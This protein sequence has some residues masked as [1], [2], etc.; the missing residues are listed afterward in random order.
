MTPSPP[1]P[2]PAAGPLQILLIGSFGNSG[3]PVYR[4]HQQAAANLLVLV[5][6]MDVELPRLVRQRRL[7][8]RPTVLEV[9]DWVP[10]VQRCNPVNANWSD[11]RAWGL[12][13]QLI[14]HCDAVQVS[15]PG[16][17]RRLRPLARSVWL[18]RSSTTWVGWRGCTSAWPP[19]CPAITTPVD[20]M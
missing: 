13:S 19:C 8:G 12:L 6:G 20:R 14:P 4:V 15:S 2:S 10:G 18:A 16:L 5:M 1:A 11:S 17:L 3:D 7:L 9:N